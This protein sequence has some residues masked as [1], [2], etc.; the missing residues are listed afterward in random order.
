MKCSKC[1]LTSFDHNATCP[2]CGRDLTGLREQLGLL[3]VEPQRVNFLGSLLME[4]GGLLEE[5]EPLEAEDSFF[6]EEEAESLE[7]YDEEGL[8]IPEEVEAAVDLETISTIEFESEPESELEIAEANDSLEGEIEFDME[9]EGEDLELGI[10]EG[11]DLELGVEEPSL[12]VEMEAPERETRPV[13]SMDFDETFIIE[14]EVRAELAEVEADEELSLEAELEKLDLEVRGEEPEEEMPLVD[15]LEETDLELEG[16]PAEEDVSLEPEPEELGLE[17]ETETAEE[18]EMELEMPDEEEPLGAEA[19]GIDLDA[20][21]S[22]VEDMTDEYQPD[23]DEE[24]DQI[25]TDER[26][27][28]LEPDA[29][30]AREPKVEAAPESQMIMEEEE[31]EDELDLSSLDL[32]LGDEEGDIEIGD[33]D[34]LDLSS[35]EIEVDED[36]LSEEISLPSEPI[37]D[38]MIEDQGVHIDDGTIIMDDDVK[39]LDLS[40]GE[41]LEDMELNFDDLEL[42]DD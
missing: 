29:A 8:E 28:I 12:E 14:P 11:E 20:L 23:E 30:S 17:V 2:K 40:G 18:L 42:E 13:D 1:G 21:E 4:E 7:A 24:L 32:D 6:E 27:L 25:V 34:E 38:E 35:L 33:I 39:G 19:E 16:E 3:A 37:V 22:E 9:A 5:Q 41:D 10:A 36:I 15:E 31:L 26:T